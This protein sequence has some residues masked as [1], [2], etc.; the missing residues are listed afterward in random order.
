M[1]DEEQEDPGPIWDNDWK[2]TGIE[3]NKER[4]TATPSS[5]GYGQS[6]RLTTPLPKEG[7]HC[8]EYVYTRPGKGEDGATLGDG[9]M[10][11]VVKAALPVEL[12]TEKGGVASSGGWWGLLDTYIGSV[13][14][15]EGIKGA[16]TL[17]TKYIPASARNDHGQAFGSGDRI[18]FAI[19]MDNGTMNFFR[20]GKLLP[21]A[22]IEDLPITEEE[23]YVVG[24]P[25]DNGATL[26]IMA[27]A[28]T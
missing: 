4:D 18:G 27:A 21:G 5:S 11:G 14:E 3:L 12:Y 15:G 10:V 9:Y 7:V 2:G 17:V 13:Y 20:N 24:C 16:P 22:T 25:Y 28:Y 6:V 1:A 19:D 26:K 23:F 8:F